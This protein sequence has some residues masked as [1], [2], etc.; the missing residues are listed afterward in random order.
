VADRAEIAELTANQARLQRAWGEEREK[1]AQ[2]CD[3][4]DQMRQ[5][6]SRT[7]AAIVEMEAEVARLEAEVERLTT[8]IARQAKSVAETFGERG[9]DNDDPTAEC[10]HGIHPNDCIACTPR[11]TAPPAASAMERATHMRLRWE[12]SHPKEDRTLDEENARV[13]EQAEAAGF[14][15]AIDKTTPGFRDLG[16]ALRMIRDAVAEL[17][18]V[19][20]LPSRDVGPPDP[21]GE[22]EDIIAGIMAIRDQAE[23]AATDRERQRCATLDNIDLPRLLAATRVQAFE[24]AALWHETEASICD[25]VSNGRFS[26]QA[27][28][29]REYAAA[30]CAT[31]PSRRVRNS[32]VRPRIRGCVACQAPSGGGIRCH[33]A[34]TAMPGSSAG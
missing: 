4:V 28:L 3:T 19:G 1:V 17:A 8:L 16:I 21:I 10:I 29:H 31:P 25:D 33:S 15:S 23:A 7:C 32:A 2:L 5:Q 27:Q 11:L 14:R 34:R 9:P 6:D 18:P 22:G 12:N 30:F 20:G 24:E 26:R 13:I